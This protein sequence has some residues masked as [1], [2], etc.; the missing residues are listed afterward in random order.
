MK[1]ESSG[2]AHGAARW[3]ALTMQAND[4]GD[5]GG[6]WAGLFDAFVLYPI[7]SAHDFYTCGMHLLGKPDLIAASELVPAAGAAELFRVFALYLLAD[8]P[9]GGFASGHTFSPS[10]TAPGFRVAWEPC[11]GYA[12]DDFFFNPF[13]RWRFA[14]L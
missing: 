4:P 3:R 12:E 13:G 7:Q 2:I 14:A 5:P 9:D 11:T 8:C 6:R 1:C 10:E